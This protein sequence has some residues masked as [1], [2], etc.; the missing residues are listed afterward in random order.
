[1][2]GGAW[3]VGPRRLTSR[4]RR[5]YHLAGACDTCVVKIRWAFNPSPVPLQ[6]LATRIESGWR[7]KE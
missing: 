4:R 3:Q 6:G 2:L 7:E 5:N 1:V